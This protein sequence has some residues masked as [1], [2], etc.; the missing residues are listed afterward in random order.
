MGSRALTPYTSIATL[1]RK[2]QFVIYLPGDGIEHV[3][4]IRKEDRF[5]IIH[6]TRMHQEGMW[7][8]YAKLTY[9]WQITPQGIKIT[10]IIDMVEMMIFDV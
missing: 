9:C 4:C 8:F 5:Y 3:T 7:E 10:N 2:T 1:I 6:N